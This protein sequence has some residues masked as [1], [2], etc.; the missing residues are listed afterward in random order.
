MGRPITHKDQ[1]FKWD[2]Q[3]FSDSQNFFFF[4]FFH[5]IANKKYINLCILKGVL[6]SFGEYIVLR[7]ETPSF[8]IFFMPK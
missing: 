8:I 7:R 2:I 6:C 5:R 3:L 1:I 4:L